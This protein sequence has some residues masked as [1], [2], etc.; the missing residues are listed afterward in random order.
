MQ[1][2]DSE[3]VLPVSDREASVNDKNIYLINIAHIHTQGINTVI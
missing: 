1:C 2:P 3:A